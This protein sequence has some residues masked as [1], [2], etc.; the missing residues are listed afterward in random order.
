MGN[1][2]YVMPVYKQ[3]RDDQCLQVLE[4]GYVVG[5]LM[6]VEGGWKW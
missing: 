5:S 3:L 6:E 4:E 2:K 1:Q